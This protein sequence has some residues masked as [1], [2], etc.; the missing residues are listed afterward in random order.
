MAILESCR[1][2]IDVAVV[3]AVDLEVAFF[4]ESVIRH[5]LGMIF[6]EPCTHP[7]CRPYEVSNRCGKIYVS[8]EV[9]TSNTVG[10]VS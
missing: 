2:V 7:L 1:K 5:S 9:P 6:P 8:P 3:D 10:A 4:H